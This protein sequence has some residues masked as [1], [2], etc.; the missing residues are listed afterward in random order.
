MAPPKCYHIVTGNQ[1][2]AVRQDRGEARYSSPSGA[3]RRVVV[4]EKKRPDLKPGRIHIIC[5]RSLVGLGFAEH[6]FENGVHV[7]GVITHV[8]F[9]VDPI[10]AQSGNN[11]GI[12]QQLFTEIDALFPDLQ[13]VALNH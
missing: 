6:P 5:F 10:G 7:F 8:E 9:F 1:R 11:I 12:S 3:Q 13:R 4:S 2:G